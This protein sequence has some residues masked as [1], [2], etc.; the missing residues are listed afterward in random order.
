VSGAAEKAVCI[1]S[2]PRPIGD[3]ADVCRSKL[4]IS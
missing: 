4:R 1:S 2:M 3:V